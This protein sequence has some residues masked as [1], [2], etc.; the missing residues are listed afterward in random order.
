MNRPWIVTP[1]SFFG[2]AIGIPTAVLT[3]LV[4]DVWWLLPVFGV[5]IGYVTNWLALWMIY[6][7]VE[8]R[9]LF[10]RFTIQGLFIRRQPEVAGVY[11]GIIADDII[12]VQNMGEEL[13]QGPRSDRTRQMIEDGL[14]PAVDRS[15][16]VVQPAVRV[17]MG[18]KEYDT[19]R[20][21]IASEGVEYTMTPLTDEDFNREQSERVRELIHERMLELPHEDFSDMLRSVTKQDEWLLLLHGAV[22]GFGGGLVHL[23]F[24]G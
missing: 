6:E 20:D 8:P 13:L 23:L 3:V 4:F 18:T 24:F 5:L 12:T 10:G 21:S 9:K 11:A 7:P 16:G 15:L 14:K 1:K 19:I 22:L 17:A 2:F